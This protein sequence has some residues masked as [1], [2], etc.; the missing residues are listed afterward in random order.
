MCIIT[1]GRKQ[2]I[3][4]RIVLVNKHLDIFIAGYLIIKVIGRLQ[5]Q[6]IKSL[7][8]ALALIPCCEMDIEWFHAMQHRTID[9]LSMRN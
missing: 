5:L 9:V 4:I 8:Y 1:S 7:E 2:I 3:V 6:S